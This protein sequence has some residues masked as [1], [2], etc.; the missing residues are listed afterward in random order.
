MDPNTAMEAATEGAKAL[1]KLQEIIQ[2]VFSPHW[3]KKQADADAYAD[4]RKLQTIRD[5]PD[6]EIVYV[7]SE[8]HA[9]ERTPEALAYRAKQRELAE[10]IRQE[11]NLENV[12][13]VAANEISQMELVSDK[14]VDED[15]LI[16]LF[17]IAKS[18][19]SEDMQFVWGKILAGEILEPGTFS[20][21][22]LETIRNMC[23]S[24]AEDFQKIA[25]LV[26][27]AGNSRFL[28]TN[29][30]ILD[31]Y[32]A[33]FEV[34]S[35]LDE[36]GLIDANGFAYRT[37][38]NEQS[39]KYFFFN[40]E[41]ILLPSGD[42]P[43]KVDINTYFLTKAGKELLSIIEYK[44]NNDYFFDVVNTIWNPSWGKEF[45]L[46]IHEIDQIVDGKIS[47]KHPPIKEYS[48]N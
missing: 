9:R 3:T 2:K 46:R 17:C 19:S 24:E 30:T 13:D 12:L 11:A 42:G 32:G 34:L 6:M 33:T 22:T 7:G 14:P 29:S 4:E 8:M 16:R 26:L 37:Y 20:L 35:A 21:R 28:T 40:D 39:H 43:Y 15:W 25:P 5:N 44:P 45:S 36:C 48:N 31:K 18:V 10:S 23:K 38:R 47:I 1:T 41:I 27:K